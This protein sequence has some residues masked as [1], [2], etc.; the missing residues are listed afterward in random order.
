MTTRLITPLGKGALAAGATILLTAALAGAAPFSVHMQDYHSGQ[1]NKRGDTLNLEVYAPKGQALTAAV[2]CCREQML[3]HGINGWAMFAER[4]SDNST[5]KRNASILVM[6]DVLVTN[7]PV[8]IAKMTNGATAGIAAFPIRADHP[9]GYFQL[10]VEILDAQGR[11]MES[12]I[13]YVDR[14]G[15]GLVTSAFAYNVPLELPAKLPGNII[16]IDGNGLQQY[17]ITWMKMHGDWYRTQAS[18]GAINTSRLDSISSALDALRAYDTK[19]GSET[20]VMFCMA[21]GIHGFKPS[22]FEPAFR[23]WAELLLNR[24]GDRVD[25]WDVWNEP[26]S[27][28]YAIMEDR[29]IFALKT[30]HEL[31]RKR[32][33]EVGIILSPHTSAGL[34]YIKR[35][36]D[37]GAAKY[38]T[39]MGLHPYRGVPPEVPEPDGYTGNPTGQRTLLSEI[40]D[41]KQLLDEYGVKPG[42]IYLNETTFALNILPDIDENDQANILVRSTIIAKT[43][44]YVKS[45]NYHGAHSRLTLVSLPNLALHLADTVFIAKLE[46]ADPA[47]H[48]YLFKKGDGRLSL[49]LWSIGQDKLVNVEG[50]PSKPAITDIYGNPLAFE[51]DAQ[52]GLVRNLRLSQAPVYILA[53][54][55][56]KPRLTQNDCLEITCPRS[57][58][59]GG[60]LKLGIRISP[61]AGGFPAGATTLQVDVSGIVSNA[62][63][64]QAVAPGQDCHIEVAIPATAAV[65]GGPVRFALLT[66]AGQEVA[67][68]DRLLEIVRPP[69]EEDALYGVRLREDFDSSA[70]DGWKIQKSSQSAID[71]AEVGGRRVL[72]IIQKFI[73]LPAS[74]ERA[75]APVKYGALSFDLSMPEVAQTLTVSLGELKLL[76]DGN[77]A[78]GVVAGNGVFQKAGA[79]PA[80]TN[81]QYRVF[82]AAPEGWCRIWRNEAFLGQ[83]T[84][85]ASY[86][87]YS[88][89][90][91]L[92][93]TRS[94]EKPSE[95]LIGHVCLTEIVP[96]VWDA[97]ECLR[98]TICGPFPNRE[99]AKT[100]KR[101]SER[102]VDYLAALGGQI[103]LNA[104]PGLAVKA[105]AHNAAHNAAG[106]PDGRT[107]TFSAPYTATRF[108]RIQDKVINYVDFFNVDHLKLSQLQADIICYAAAYLLSDEAR[109]VTFGMGSDDGYH[110]W[111]NNAFVGM[112]NAY[113]TGR[114]CGVKQETYKVKLRKG[115]NLIML[116]VDQGDGSFAFT[117][118]ME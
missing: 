40:R 74:I 29:D 111:V 88:G 38:L 26:D 96:Q 20:K 2:F 14:K 110:L 77:G 51:Y 106:R 45:I 18:D 5:N 92:A 59:C 12:R 67:L 34:N 94:T 21:D 85:P 25:V 22:A 99:D 31:T 57:V 97:K 75:T 98:F 107:L 118:S 65:A 41:T 56:S 46:V 37:K 35:I 48:A 47:I 87:G 13:M 114:G 112:F 1:I 63:I 105:P 55:G 11:Q 83:F 117:V 52:A 68:A 9:F 43:Q 15:R 76:F 61:S 36:L 33:P 66:A 58:P 32:W 19:Q 78:F 6:R 91:F 84:I 10:Q 82:F 64:R 103:E 30:V 7:L 23:S 44:N 4:M 49:P 72:R 102:D 101:P 50:L 95:F 90:Q 71:T 54:P 100:G 62:P 17:G 73:D 89:A 79:C 81:G 70:L 113:P 60:I 115:L 27:K 108:A 24:Y 104:Y 42:Y 116:A 86:G 39:G 28:P 109:E 80:M 3:V 69:A 16:G 8:T 93:G 53:A